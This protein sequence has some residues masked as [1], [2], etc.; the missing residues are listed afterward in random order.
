MRDVEVSGTA[1]ILDKCRGT[2]RHVG[3]EEGGRGSQGDGPPCAPVSRDV[4]TIGTLQPGPFEEAPNLGVLVLAKLVEIDRKVNHAAQAGGGRQSRSRLKQLAGLG[5]GG[6]RHGLGQRT[7]IVAG[8]PDRVAAG[9][10]TAMNP[11]KLP[12]TRST[13]RQAGR[14]RPQQRGPAPGLVEARPGNG[15][16]RPQVAQAVKGCDGAKPELPFPDADAKTGDRAGRRRVRKR[17]GPGIDDVQ[18]STPETVG[19]E[20]P[21]DLPVVH[22][23]PF[24]RRDERAVVASA[25][26]L[27]GLQEE[28]DVQARELAR[29]ET[30]GSCSARHPAFPICR[31]L[32]VADIGGVAEEQRRPIRGRKYY[33][34]IVLQMHGQAARHVQRGRIG[35][36]H[37]CRQG[38]D[39]DRN[40]LGV[41]ECLA[42]SKEEP[43]RAGPRIDNPCRRLLSRGPGN[44]GVD[45]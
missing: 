43:A 7:P 23:E 32:V 45:N 35:P 26:K 31:D 15:P 27:A 10:L 12:E 37:E 5:D 34:P 33:C 11:T 40:Q 36:D 20:S 3:A 38:I 39:L 22:V 8:N 41:G 29:L 4:G 16:S 14:I 44:H 1:G 30:V 19:E 2:T 13:A 25:G 18:R 42:G 21:Q 17:H 28:M 24:R 6:D 9:H